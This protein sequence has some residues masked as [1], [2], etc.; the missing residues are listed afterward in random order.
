MQP[1]T[2]KKETSCMDDH[3]P[4]SLPADVALKKIISAIEPVTSMEKVAIRTALGRILAEDIISTINVPSG[5]N[6]AM[7]GYAITSADIPSTGTAELKMM[8]TAYAGKP[9][10]GKV[11]SGE[12]V[13]I[14]TGAIMPSGSDTVVMQ[15]HVE[16]RHGSIRI[17]TDTKAGANVRQAGEDVTKGDVVLGKGTTLTPADIGLIASL[18]LAE[19]NVSRRLRVAFFSTGDECSS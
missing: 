12:C 3:D 18:G 2:I 9:F 7:D 1:D 6:S 5:T 16:H 13:R 4:A 14:M 15:E 8:G 11:S 19:V 10:P 17:D